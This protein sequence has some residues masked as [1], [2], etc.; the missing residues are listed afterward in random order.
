MKFFL[1]LLISI[2][3]LSISAQSIQGILVD[4]NN[5]PMPFATVQLLGSD[6]SLLK[7]EMSKQDGKFRFTNLKASNYFLEVN[8]LG[9]ENLKLEVDLA[10][11]DGNLKAIYMQKKSMALDAVEIKAEKPMIEV[12]PDKTVFNVSKNLGSTGDDGVELLRKAPGMQIDNNDNIILEGKSGVNVYIN[13]KQTF[14][15]GD[16]LTNYLKSIRAE[17]IEKVEIITQPSS[18][19]DA[20]GNAGIINIVLKRE[21]GLGTKGSIANT[22]TYGQFG[23]NNTTLN[24]NHRSKKFASFATLSHYQGASLRFFNIYREQENNVFDGKSEF[25]NSSMNNRLNLGGDYYLSKFSTV[26]FSASGNLN[27]SENIAESKTTIG[28]ISSNNI[29]SVLLAPNRDETDVQNYTANLNYRYKDTNNRAVEIDLDYVNYSNDR[30]SLQPNIYTDPT[31]NFTLNE[32]INF[33]RTPID[34]EVYSAKIDYEQPFKKGTLSTGAKISQ[35]NTFNTFN[36]FDV[37]NGQN[38]LDSSRS[39]TFEYI[40]TIAA[41]YVNYKFSYKKFKFQGGLRAEQTF[42][43]GELIALIPN[44]DSTVKREYLNW[45]PSAGITYQLNKNNSTAL[46]YSRRIERPNYQNLNPFESQINELSFRRG[47]PFLQP[48]F[49]HNIKLSNTY[50]Y[51]LNTSF[52]FS[53]ISDYFAEVT[54]AEGSRRSFIN[55]RNVADQQVYNLSVSYPKK[56]NKWW[57]VYGSLYGY[58]TKFT[59]NHPD[60]IPIDRI[61]YGGYAQSTFKLPKN[62]KAEVSGWYSSPSIWRGTFRTKSIGS[63]N[64]AV[65]KSWKQW[66]TKLSFNDILYTVPWRADNRF[67]NLYLNGTGGSDSRNVRF[68]VSYSFGQKDVKAAK[69]RKSGAEDE[70]NR[71]N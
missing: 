38:N 46:I 30:E 8:Y 25:E 20:A 35:V 17:E 33:Q 55:T 58:Y 56:I 53:Y 23:R 10:V 12:E 2:I 5:N 13:G 21:K 57:S 69:T 3:T 50:K 66:T 51:T 32:N 60:F 70:Q 26:G 48:Q 65:Q 6:T 28:Q 47:N 62:Y 15:Q 9:Y 61:I 45:F 16:D 19:Y 39:N 52:T 54:E 44:A 4:E 63:L 64:L 59:A 42:S 68:Y 36:F 11:N 24:I 7:V 43:N 34:I 22:Y 41:A 1:T 31:E 14:L 18:K 67:G 49:T 37:V 27:N 71:L 29:D 40:E